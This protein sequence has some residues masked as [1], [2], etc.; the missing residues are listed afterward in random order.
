MIEDKVVR[1]G[2]QEAL[3]LLQQ[4]LNGYRRFASRIYI[5]VTA[6]P[7]RR[8]NEHAQNGWQKMVL[9]YEAFNPEIACEL[10][11][12][13]IRYAASCNFLIEPD[14]I[15]PGGEGIGAQNRVNFVYLLVA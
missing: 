12:S 7:E 5:G 10:E 1:V 3:P 11:R 13:L 4:K 14:N 8:W 2:R 9:L 15:N 6:H